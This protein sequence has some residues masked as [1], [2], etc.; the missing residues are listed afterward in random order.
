MDYVTV[1]ILA[2]VLTRR[3]SLLIR[4]VGID[5]VEGTQDGNYTDDL[6]MITY[7]EIP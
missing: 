5:N 1:I 4:K 3:Q 7:T 6:R 2:V